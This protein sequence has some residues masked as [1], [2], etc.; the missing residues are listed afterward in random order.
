MD[1]YLVEYWI[2]GEFENSQYEYLSSSN[3][4]EAC[5]FGDMESQKLAIAKYGE[6]IL[7]EA[8]GHMSL[9]E[10]DPCYNEILTD[11]IDDIL[12]SDYIQYA[13]YRVVPET[14][15][16]AIKEWID[17]VEKFINLW[18]VQEC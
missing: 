17:D 9:D 14:P 15:K 4:C 7:K 16:D 18:T 3:Y 10:S 5:L 8:K 11:I 13:V 1:D 6:D 2:S 12:L